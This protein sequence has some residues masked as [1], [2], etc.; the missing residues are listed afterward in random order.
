MRPGRYFSTVPLQSGPMRA[1][2]VAVLGVGVA[3]VCWVPAGG[4]DAVVT[5][6]LLQMFA[7]SSGFAIPARRG[8]YD[9]LLT[10]GSSR[11]GVAAAHLAWSVGPG[12]LAWAVLGIVE[13]L[14]GGGA[15]RSS[16]SVVALALVSCGA[17]A[18][19]VPLPRLSGGVMWLVLL[20]AGLG[21]PSVW[22][23]ELLEVAVGEGTA[24]AR[25]VAYILCPLVLGGRSLETADVVAVLPALVLVAGATGAAW[26]YVLRM[27]VALEGA[28]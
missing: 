12:V 28:Q 19:T 3:Q 4:Q 5:L 7:A 10:G 8:H 24:T 25:T 17:W 11:A 22:R 27:D 9:T 26:R 18:I 1:G 20:L 2:L 6:L 16:G 15:V 23:Q 14:A 13:L 21:W